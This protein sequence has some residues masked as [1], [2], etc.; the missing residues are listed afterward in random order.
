M[1]VAVTIQRHG[2]SYH[3]NNKD[4]VHGHTWRKNSKDKLLIDKL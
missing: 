4:I 2:N 1:L 3:T